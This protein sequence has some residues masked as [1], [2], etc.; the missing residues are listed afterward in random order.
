MW[1]G[2]IPQIAS[3]LDIKMMKQWQRLWIGRLAVFNGANFQVPGGIFKATVAGREVFNTIEAHL[4]QHIANELEVIAE[5]MNIVAVL[6][7]AKQASKA[8][9]T[10]VFSRFFVE[11]GMMIA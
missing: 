4:V 9:I 8:P 10:V 11:K 5:F 1:V 7:P 3:M 6:L 2:K